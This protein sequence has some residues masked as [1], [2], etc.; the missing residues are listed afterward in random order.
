M[1]VCVFGFEVAHYQRELGLVVALRR[2]AE[3]L[4]PAGQYMLVTVMG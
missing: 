4:I 1:K 3:G 2:A